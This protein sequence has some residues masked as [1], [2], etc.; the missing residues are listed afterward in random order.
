MDG[1]SERNDFFHLTFSIEIQI[2]TIGHQVP[3]IDQ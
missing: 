1:L 2:D 3:G